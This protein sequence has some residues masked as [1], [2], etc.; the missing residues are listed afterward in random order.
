MTSDETITLSVQDGGT[1]EAARA[2][3]AIA[4]ELVREGVAVVPGGGTPPD[5]SKGGSHLEPGS[6]TIGAAGSLQAFRSIS[7]VVTGAIRRGLVGRISLAD[8]DRKLVVDSS[9]RESEEALV[10][11]L[12]RSKIVDPDGK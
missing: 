7:R 2:A 5:G 10:A 8:G 12:H 4:R 1:T 3:T 11:W 9:S 6:L